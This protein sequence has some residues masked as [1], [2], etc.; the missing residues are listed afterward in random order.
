MAFTGFTNTI[1][2]IVIIVGDNLAYYTY[3][4]YN[5]NTYYTG[6]FVYPFWG[7]LY[8]DY[9]TYPYPSRMR[10]RI[11]GDA[12]NRYIVFEWKEMGWYT[13]YYNRSNF[14]FQC[15]I[16]E[17]SSNIEFHYGPMSRG[18]ATVGGFYYDYGSYGNYP[19]SAL[20][21]FSS[22]WPK[23][24]DYI[25]IDPN[26]NGNMGNGTWESGR[27]S[28]PLSGGHTYYETVRTNGDFD[29]IQ[30]GDVVFLTYGYS[31]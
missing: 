26:G 23:T 3:Y 24:T 20:I 2:G 28:A 8:Y 11:F 5:Y 7:Y 25:N 29:A 31:I 6:G 18:N 16:H 21:G 22:Y 1:V 19:F 30:T 12:P 9:T 4:R 15:I 10:F 17:T 27:P 13:P 14:N